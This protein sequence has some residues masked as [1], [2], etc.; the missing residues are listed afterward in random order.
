[1][2]D[3]GEG[4]Q[5]NGKLQKPLITLNELEDIDYLLPSFNSL[6][7]YLMAFLLLQIRLSYGFGV[8]V[9]QVFR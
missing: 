9:V 6:L 2:S 7:G 8:F 1:M 4:G 3:L 5:W